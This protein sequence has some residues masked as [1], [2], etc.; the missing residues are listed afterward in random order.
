MPLLL[1]DAE[2]LIDVEP[3]QRKARPRSAATV[4][5]GAGSYQAKALQR[6]ENAACAAAYAA[7]N[8]SQQRDCVTSLKTRRWRFFLCADIALD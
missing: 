4:E 3:K 8:T 5:T 7:A 1:A 6:L 2:A